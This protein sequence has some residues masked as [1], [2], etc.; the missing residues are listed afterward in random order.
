[1][2]RREF[3]KEGALSL[4]VLAG[5]SLGAAYVERPLQADDVLTLGRSKLVAT[6][7]SLGLGDGKAEAFQRMGQAG[8]SRLIRHALDKGVRYFDLLPGPAHEMLA[9]ALKG[10]P[11][12]RYTLV[13]NFRHPEEQ[14][15]ARMIERFLKELKTDYL[16]AVLVGAILSKD[17]ATED[18][19]T[20]RRD[21]LS[22]AK[23]AGRV[24]AHGVSVHGWEALRSIAGDPWVELALVSCNH[25]GTW[26]D[27]PAGKQVTEIERRD[28]S[29]PPIRDVHAAGIGTAGMKIFSHSGYR[30]ARNPAEERLRAIRF[31]MSLGS[32]D[33]MPIMCESI[34]EF[35]E[36]RGMINR[37]GAE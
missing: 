18:R 2:D 22:A 11:R 20:E 32:I 36:V 6:R 21:L 30:E 1:M 31:V 4:A 24:I 15:P 5:P 27:A 7:Q 3:I 26:M 35:D 9:E 23:Q 8:F 17:W 10:V 12:E 19:W 25:K 29:V 37:V 16:D 28:L 13:T 14:N 34:Q 33:T